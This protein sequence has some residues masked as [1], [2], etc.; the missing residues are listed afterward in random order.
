M[1]KP[2]Q[3][4]KFSSE[5]IL[6]IGQDIEGAPECQ[7]E[8]PNLASLRKVLYINGAVENGGLQSLYETHDPIVPF[9]EMAAA[10]HSL[11]L[12]GYS[13]LFDEANALLLTDGREIVEEKKWRSKAVL[14]NLDK[15]Q[16]KYECCEVNVAM[17]DTAVKHLVAFP[18]LR[19]V[20]FNAAG[21]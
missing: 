12:F 11:G 16:T 15:L 10:Y 18:A 3:R 8:I 2:W 1:P 17:I 7:P 4:M 20:L 21:E 6:A 5:L 19:Q 9:R 14:Q 13:D